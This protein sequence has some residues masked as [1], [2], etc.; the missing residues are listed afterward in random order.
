MDYYYC[1]LMV[2]NVVMNDIINIVVVV[3]NDIINSVVV[4]DCYYVIA[5]DYY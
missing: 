2:I 1:F 3:I 4:F 5:I